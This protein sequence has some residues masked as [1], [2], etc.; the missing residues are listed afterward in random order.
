MVAATGTT[1]TVTTT[2][3]VIPTMTTTTDT[4]TMPVIPTTT[5]A[6]RCLRVGTILVATGARIYRIAARLEEAIPTCA[7]HA[8]WGR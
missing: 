3:P 5:S 4:T 2:M 6:A 1:T 8:V 7:A